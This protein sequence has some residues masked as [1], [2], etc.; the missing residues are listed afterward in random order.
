[1]SIESR[2]FA[3]NVAKFPT[4]IPAGNVAKFPET[5]TGKPLI[6]KQKYGKSDGILQ[7]VPNDSLILDE[8][9]LPQVNT[10]HCIG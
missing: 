6:E 10:M 7:W 1:M 3:G 2:I 5:Q 8:V 4:R 9:S